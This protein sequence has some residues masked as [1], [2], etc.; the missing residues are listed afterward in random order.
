MTVS[1]SRAQ[2]FSRGAKGG[3]ALA[4]RGLASPAVLAGRRQPTRSRT[5]ILPM[6]GCSSAPSCSRPT[7]TRRR[8]RRSSSAATTSKYLNRAL[9]NEQEHYQ[10]V[11][12]DPDRCR[13][14][15]RGAPPTSTSP[16]RRARSPRRASIAKLGVTLETIFLGAYLGAVD[17]AADGRAQAAGRPDRRERGAAP[18]RLHAALRAAIPSGSPS[19]TRSRSTRL[20]T[21]STRTPVSER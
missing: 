14:G 5:P 6:H 2:L 15:R 3:A 17:G 16:I 9:F 12:R 20:R 11:V 8:S 4:H 18:E 21:R 19:P 7:S 10:A 13:P 1:L